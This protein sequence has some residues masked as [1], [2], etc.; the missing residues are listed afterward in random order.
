MVGRAAFSKSEQSG[1]FFFTIARE[2]R[3]AVLSL[4]FTHFVDL[5]SSGLSLFF[6][7]QLGYL[8]SLSLSLFLLLEQHVLR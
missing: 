4:S 5:H 8:L 2:T 7:K 1:L 3:R 6:G